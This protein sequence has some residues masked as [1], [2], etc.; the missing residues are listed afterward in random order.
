M[1]DDSSRSDRPLSPHLQVYR[2]GWTMSLSIFHR[3]SGIVLSFGLVLI[4]AWL[5]ALTAGP[6][7]YAT[8]G[9]FT[10]HWFGKLLLAAWSLA[11]FYHLCNGV[12]HLLWDMG[13]GFELGVARRTGFMVVVASVVLSILS[14]LL[15]GGVIGGGS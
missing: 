9:A 15:A 8:V 7:A 11:F 1:N 12:R 5:A 10:G 3:F 6:A 2:W 13:W 4:V 14:W